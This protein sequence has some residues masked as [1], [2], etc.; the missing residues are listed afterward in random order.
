MHV[1]E[2]K[3]REQEG[4][5]LAKARAPNP[6]PHPNQARALEAEKSCTTNFLASQKDKRVEDLHA[7]ALKRFG[8]QV[9]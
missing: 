5:A 6:H 7:R 2:G 4:V 8:N 9:S 3:L 1:M